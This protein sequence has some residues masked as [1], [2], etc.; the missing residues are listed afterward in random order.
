MCPAVGLGDPE[1]QAWWRQAPLEAPLWGRHSVRASP[2][3]AGR[4]DPPALPHAEGLAEVRALESGSVSPK[5]F[6]D[7]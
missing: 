3:E 2:Q 6:V 1:S 7:P 5:R 4:P